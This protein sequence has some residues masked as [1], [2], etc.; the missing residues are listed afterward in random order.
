MP[1]VRAI[2][3]EAKLEAVLLA[4]RT[5]AG[6]EDLRRVWT[7]SNV[8]RSI[9][10]RR[11]SRRHHV[12]MFTLAAAILHVDHVRRAPPQ[13]RVLQQGADRRRRPVRRTGSCGAGPYR[14]GRR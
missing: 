10:G 12:A 8:N 1:E 5:A 7:G 13:F 14:P 9:P 3:D 6:P 11:K 2:E 4:I